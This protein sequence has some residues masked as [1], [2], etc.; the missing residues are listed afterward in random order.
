MTE[1]SPPSLNMFA[2]GKRNPLAKAVLE[3]P[4]LCTLVF[5]LIGRV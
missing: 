4:W 3:I 5:A 1:K 2:G